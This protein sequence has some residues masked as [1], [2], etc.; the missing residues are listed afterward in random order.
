[1]FIVRIVVWYIYVASWLYNIVRAFGNVGAPELL[2]QQNQII[3]ANINEEVILNCTR[4]ISASPTPL[5]RWLFT[6]SCASCTNIDGV[7]MFTVEDITNS[8][9]YTC[10]AENQYGNLSV[11]FNVTVISKMIILNFNQG[12]IYQLHATE[13]VRICMRVG[14]CVHLCV[15]VLACTGRI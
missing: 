1:M 3:I 12:A 4:S 14:V 9:E 10:V 13:I 8:G 2:P 15:H 7:F 6:D 5:Y 11:T